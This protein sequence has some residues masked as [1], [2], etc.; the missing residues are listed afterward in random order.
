MFM[1]GEISDRISRLGKC[2]RAV[3][4]LIKTERNAAGGELV[5][6]GLV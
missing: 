1:L 6:T 3:D 5:A 4:L 2:Q